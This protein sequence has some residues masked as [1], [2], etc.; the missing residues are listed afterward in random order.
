MAT[1]ISES[2]TH[3]NQRLVHEHP[4]RARLAGALLVVSPILIVI[5]GIVLPISRT[6]WL[7]PSIQGQLA[8]IAARRMEFLLSHLVFFAGLGSTTAAL[9]ILARRFREVTP[10]RLAI[11]GAVINLGVLLAFVVVAYYRVNLPS[12]ALVAS[13]EVPPLFVAAMEGW[14]NAVFEGLIP[15][16]FLVF[17][18][19]LGLYGSLK[20]L[21]TFAAVVSGLLLV[22]L[23]VLGDLAPPVYYVATLP[24]GV[25]LLR[26]TS[27]RR[28]TE[29]DSEPEARA[30]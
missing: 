11:A 18:V 20:R 24:I 1:Q 19:A 13:G 12:A 6:V 16:S 9:V 4:G 22:L 26:L 21:G 14:M 17:G 23:L 30:G 8:T 25:Q 28:Q 5:A 3:R 7:D 2:T 27:R 15:L 10:R 29:H